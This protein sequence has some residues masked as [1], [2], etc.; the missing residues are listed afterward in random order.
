MSK[1]DIVKSAEKLVR[2]NKAADIDVCLETGV[3][4]DALTS[5]SSQI[6][7]RYHKT[8]APKANECRA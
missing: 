5:L 3:D 6:S 2:S 1:P 8:L 7:V 4:Y